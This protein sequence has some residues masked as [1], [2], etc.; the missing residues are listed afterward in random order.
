[1][2]PGHFKGYTELRRENAWA[3]VADEFKDAFLKASFLERLPQT[4]A[5]GA[6]RGRGHVWKTSLDRVPVVV[7]PYRR[8]G[9]FRNILPDLFLDPARPLKE[10]AVSDHLRERGLLTPRVIAVRGER[11][12]GFLNSFQLLSEEVTGGADLVDFLRSHAGDR[13]R[14]V[15][16]QAI[17]EIAHAV[18]SLHDSGVVHRDLNARNILVRWEGDAPRVYVLDLDRARIVSEVSPRQRLAALF[19]LNRSLE[20]IDRAHLLASASDRLR[21][22]LAYFHGN[23]GKVASL[24]PILRRSARNLRIRKMWWSLFRVRGL[25][26]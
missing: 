9:L 18:L 7:R 8:G 11:R 21:F 23:G 1:M 2:I 4:H 6:Y 25:F 22:L 10:L 14:T 15:V 24:Q 20:K 3:L 12:F 13:D 26:A 16:R 17:R 5:P 19:R